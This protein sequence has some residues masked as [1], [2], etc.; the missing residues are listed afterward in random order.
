[1]GIEDITRQKRHSLASFPNET[2]NLTFTDMTAAEMFVK[3]T[4]HISCKG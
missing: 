3:E 1:M 4:S 2:I